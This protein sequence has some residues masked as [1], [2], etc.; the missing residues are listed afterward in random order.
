M[1]NAIMLEGRRHWWVHTEQ[2]TKS[3]TVIHV[4]KVCSLGHVPNFFSSKCAAGKNCLSDGML[5]TGQAVQ[6]ID[7]KYYHANCSP[8]WN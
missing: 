3:G 1:G 8:R 6:K 7:E 2:K 5:K 4:K